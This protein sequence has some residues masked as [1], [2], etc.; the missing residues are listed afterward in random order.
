[1]TKIND[2]YW[3]LPHRVEPDD[4][5][6][7]AILQEEFSMPVVTALQLA[8]DEMG[9][10]LAGSDIVVPPDTEVTFARRENF[11][12]ANIYF[13]R[14][15]TPEIMT[16]VHLQH[17]DFSQYVD[18]TPRHL[19]YV[20]LDRFKLADTSRRIPEVAWP[21]RLHSRMSSEQGPSLHHEGGEEQLWL[22]D[23]TAE[24]NDLLALLLNKFE[25]MGRLWL[26]DSATMHG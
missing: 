17:H 25:D 9:Y 10:H 26:E 5:P 21:G 13:T 6:E 18:S 20:N 4:P 16:R 14:Y 23:T 19:F 22:Y 2:Y 11:Y 15:L 8:M 1:M 24:L 12:R 7:I 3:Q